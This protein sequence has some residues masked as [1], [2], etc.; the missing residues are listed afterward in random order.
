MLRKCQCQQQEP[1]SVLLGCIVNVSIKDLNPDGQGRWEI[2]RKKMF[3]SKAKCFSLSNVLIKLIA[4]L[5][6]NQDG[7]LTKD[8]FVDGCIKVVT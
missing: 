8:E 4:R 5:D 3:K 6:G 2:Y 1:V 7:I